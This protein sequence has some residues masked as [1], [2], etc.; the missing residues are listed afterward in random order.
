MLKIRQI[1]HLPL[2]LAF[3]GWQYLAPVGA[4]TPQ[5]SEILRCE[6]DLDLVALF[7]GRNG[8]TLVAGN[9]RGFW[10]DEG[11]EWR[12]RGEN[13]MFLGRF[14]GRG[15]F[16]LILSWG[17]VRND[18]LSEAHAL[19]NGDYLL[20]GSFTESMQVGIRTF[21]STE[22]AKALFIAR[23]DSEGGIRWISLFQGPSWKA[24]GQIQTEEE[25]GELVFCGDF[26]ER[27]TC[28]AEQLLSG[29]GEST[30]FVGIMDLGTGRVKQAR[31]LSGTTSSG[32]V[33]ATFLQ[34]HAGRIILAGN[35]DHDIQVDSLTEIAQT[36]DW[37]VFLLFL[38]RGTLRLQDLKK[39]GGVYEQRLVAGDLDK[40][41][42]DIYL[43][44]VLAG[45]LR[46]G[47]STVLQ[48]RD[49]LSDIFLLKFSSGGRLLWASLLGGDNIQAP[50]ALLKTENGLWL[51]GYS[52]GRLRWE[53]LQNPGPSTFHSFLSQW[54]AD[55]G[56]PD[57]IHL[58]QGEGT[59]F[60]NLIRQ[61]RPGTLLTSGVYRGQVRMG[62]APLPLSA[63]YSAWIGALT[64]QATGVSLRYPMPSWHLFPNPGQGSFWLEG[65]PDRA[66]LIVYSGG[67]IVYSTTLASGKERIT[68]PSSLP[69]GIYTLAVHTLGGIVGS[70]L[71][72]KQ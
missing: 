56:K 19:A 2:I 63:G 41:R 4:Q 71:Y 29:I 13:D 34:T 7:S 15:R 11:G 3:T 49:G 40:D 16:S 8:D 23:T 6:G 27:L 57:N 12:S 24:W 36:R 39:I 50:L 58:F 54:R 51:S 42:G 53:G 25:A 38:N 44:G 26:R 30:A 20:I 65:L 35:F 31:T 5:V 10:Q 66:S 33:H 9:Y 61:F 64:F 52:I 1:P 37:D 48:S 46:F 69:R 59:A 60:P 14:D 62:N 67:S 32:Q 70:R 55:S 43:T 47:E 17:G 21:Q 18:Q 72:L 22:N 28:G 68:L 45:V